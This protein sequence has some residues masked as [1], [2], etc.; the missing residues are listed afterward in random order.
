MSQNVKK[1]ILILASNPRVLA[2]AESFLRN[3]DWDIF[4]ATDVK[5]ALTILTKYKPAFM[6]ISLEHPNRKVRTLPDLL[7]Q[8]YPE[9]C[10]ILF[11]ETSTIENYGLLNATPAPYKVHPPVTGPAI[12]RAVNRYLRRLHDQ[13]VQEELLARSVRRHLGNQNLLPA[14]APT[15]K[16]DDSLLSKGAGQAFEQTVTRG[17]GKIH[18]PLIGATT[19]TA[20]IAIESE[21]FS[22]YLIAAMGGDRPF[23]GA[24]IDV[25]RERL[26]KYLRSGG[27][28]IKEGD[29]FPMKI[30]EVRFE[31]WALDY[32]EFLKKTV[33]EGHEIAL[34]FFP[35]SDVTPVI[36]QANDQEMCAVQIEDI[37]AETTLDFDLFIFLPTNQ[38]YVRYTPKDS[39]L[40]TSQKSRLLDQGIRHLHVRKKDIADFRRYRA[41]H[42]VNSLIMEYEERRRIMSA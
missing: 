7:R 6:M 16:K 22:G 12:E 38:R 33:H 4:L 34:A 13:K 21:R 9:L 20:C 17:D 42:Q 5:M 1:S 11:T 28:T 40:Y 37:H 30:R 31:G 26:V 27:E 14:W 39:I 32:A 2:P 25:I 24:F 35:M 23:D 8:T 15:P 36:G 19:N 29:S 3:R 10:V 41:Q 18:H